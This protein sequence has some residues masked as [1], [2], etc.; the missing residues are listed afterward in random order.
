MG[1]VSSSVVLV[2]SASM[3]QVGV[4]VG[5]V[6]VYFAVVPSKGVV[7]AVS[8]VGGLSVAPCRGND[9]DVVRLWDLVG[10]FLAVWEWSFVSNRTLVSWDVCTGVLVVGLEE[11]VV[12]LDSVLYLVLS[13]LVLISG[14]WWVSLG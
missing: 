9:T 13:V 10:S 12:R 14:R 4:S 5:V 3:G 2:G 1:W 7:W 8:R 11:C 6:L